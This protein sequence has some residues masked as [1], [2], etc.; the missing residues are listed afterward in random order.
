MAETD[1]GI[2]LRQKRRDFGLTL[3]DVEYKQRTRFDTAAPFGSFA[4]E[5]DRTTLVIQRRYPT[6][7]DM[8]SKF[9]GM[10]RVITFFIFTFVSIH[11]LVVMERY[12]LNKS[13]L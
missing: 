10:S 11:Q 2:I 1:D 5:L 8:I 4:F 6:L 7:V 13:I 3:K 9:G 12:I